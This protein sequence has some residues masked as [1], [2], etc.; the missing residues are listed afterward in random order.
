MMFLFSLIPYRTDYITAAVPLDQSAHSV[1][2]RAEAT[3]PRIVLGLWLPTMPQHMGRTHAASTNNHSND[4]SAH[5]RSAS[6]R[7]AVPGPCLIMQSVKRQSLRRT[8]S[9]AVVGM[10]MSGTPQRAHSL[11]TTAHPGDA[12]CMRLLD[13]SAPACAAW[14]AHQQ[15]T[16]SPLLVGHFDCPFDV[17][18]VVNS[19]SEAVT[20][21]VTVVPGGGVV[22]LDSSVLTLSIEERKVTSR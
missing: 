5:A 4:P 10:R 9:G 3:P 7:T 16:S 17:P 19:S 20:E 13:C 8:W 18:V 21:A 11:R 2:P 14:I 6:Q 15:S 22:A 1:H 12:R